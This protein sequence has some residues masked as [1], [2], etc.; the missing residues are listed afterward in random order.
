VWDGVQNDNIFI[1]HPDGYCSALER[2]WPSIDEAIDE[3]KSMDEPQ[4]TA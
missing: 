4:G 1:L 2:S 3:M